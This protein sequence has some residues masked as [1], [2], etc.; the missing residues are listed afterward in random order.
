MK[1]VLPARIWQNAMEVLRERP[2]DLERVVYFDGCRLEPGLGVITTLTIPHAEYTHGHFDVPAEE[3]S[4]AGQHLRRLGLVRLAQAH[5]HPADWTG[6]SPYDNEM[7][8][9]QRD[10][11]I[12]IVIPNFAGCASGLADCGVHIRERRG[13]RQLRPSELP[14]TVQVVPS[15][16]DV[17]P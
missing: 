13:W 10:G 12:S 1:L 3:M 5:T 2:H 9:S 4:R 6:H 15:L 17:R 11:A 8:F 7:A 14:D 16:I